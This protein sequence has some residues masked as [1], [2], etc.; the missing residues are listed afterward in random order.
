MTD[1]GNVLKE[2]L[3]EYGV[4][5]LHIVCKP[6]GKIDIMLDHNIYYVAQE[7][8]ERQLREAL[9]VDQIFYSDVA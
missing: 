5:W 9:P 4:N 7:K 8:M 2:I 3:D 1:T 6:T